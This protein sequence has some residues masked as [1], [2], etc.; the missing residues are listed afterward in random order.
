[1]SF[2]SFGGLKALMGLF[3]LVFSFLAP[4]FPASWGDAHNVYGTV[5]RIEISIMALAVTFIV[6]GMICGMLYGKIR[7]KKPAN[8]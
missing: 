5:Y 6:V 8:E 3:S 4:I 1:M 2:A 7:T